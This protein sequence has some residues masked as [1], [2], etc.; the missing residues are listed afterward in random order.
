MRA[1]THDAH[2]G[3]ASARWQGEQAEKEYHFQKQKDTEKKRSLI[4]HEDREQGQKS[5]SRKARP[6]EFLTI[7]AQGRTKGRRENGGSRNQ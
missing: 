5:D 7:I 6:F 1:V 3:E 4:D 2:A